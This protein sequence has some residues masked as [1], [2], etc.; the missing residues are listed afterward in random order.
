MAA[1]EEIE[2]MFIGSGFSPRI[3]VKE[4]MG[5]TG[6]A[7]STCRTML[8]KMWREGRL[9]RSMSMSGQFEYYRRTVN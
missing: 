6:L 4:A 3:T 1:R 2:Q 9:G 7:Y 8:V 5:A